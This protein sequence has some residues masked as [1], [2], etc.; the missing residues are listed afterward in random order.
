VVRDTGAG[1]EAAELP[2]VFEMFYQSNGD[3]I[4]AK[5]GLGIGLALVKRIVEMH[6]GSIEVTSDGPDRGSEFVVRLPLE[7]AAPAV[8]APRLEVAPPAKGARG[9]RILVVDDNEDSAESLAMLL[10]LSGHE[11]HV[12]RSG[13]DALTRADALRP[14]AILLDLGLPGLNGYEVCRRLRAGAWAGAIP[15]IAITGWGQA[16][17][18]QRSKDAGFDGHLVKPVV[19]AELTALLQG[20]LR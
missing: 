17:D 8:A 10:S 6:D 4:S 12:A 20:S 1:I 13:P 18:R 16:E 2:R 9:R 7:Q 15:I 3:G 19:L 11:T 5:G 14:D